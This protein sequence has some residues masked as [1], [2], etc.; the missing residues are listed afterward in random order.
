MNTSSRVPGV[1]R[2]SGW[3]AID[4]EIDARRERQ[5]QNEL[6]PGSIAMEGCWSPGLTLASTPRPGSAV[7]ET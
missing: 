3:Q 4:A 7:R 6:D 2:N 1:S 5:R